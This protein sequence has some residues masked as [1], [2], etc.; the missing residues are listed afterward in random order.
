MTAWMRQLTAARL[1]DV[2]HVPCSPL[3]CRHACRALYR[4]LLGATWGAVTRAAEALALCRCGTRQLPLQREVGRA[5]LGRDGIGAGRCPAALTL[6]SDQ[7][8][9]L[10]G[11]SRRN[12]CACC[13]CGTAR[14]VY[15][16][17]PTRP[18]GRRAKLRALL[19]GVVVAGG[20]GAGGAA[21]PAG[22]PVPARRLAGQG[23]RPAGCRSRAQA[24]ARAGGE[25]Q[26]LHVRAH[27]RAGEGAQR[28]CGPSAEGPKPS[29][30]RWA[31]GAP[32]RLPPPPHTHT[33]PV[34]GGEAAAVREGFCE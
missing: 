27:A 14:R 16:V 2:H 7:Q 6:H 1:L 13:Q 4:R 22:Q 10:P 26:G 29:R 23:G 32:A 8:P 9:A 24:A 21:Q 15:A 28:V 11:T 30:C 25:E 18:K 31:S 34:P 20:G 5:G 33:P 19:C 12:T 3:P 17:A